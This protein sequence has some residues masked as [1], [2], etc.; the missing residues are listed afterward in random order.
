MSQS[1]GHGKGWTL[2]DSTYLSEIM[3]MDMDICIGEALEGLKS[4]S[5][6]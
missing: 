4:I 3:G 5:E 6:E 2:K 1:M